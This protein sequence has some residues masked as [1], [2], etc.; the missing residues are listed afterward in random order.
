MK[1]ADVGKLINPNLIERTIDI[2]KFSVVE[3]LEFYTTMYRIRVSE[4][5]VADAKRDG[6]IRGLFI[7]ASAKKL[8]RLELPVLFEKLTVSSALTALMVI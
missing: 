8:F 7:S 4:T 1:T 3:L 6:L 5:I 2:S